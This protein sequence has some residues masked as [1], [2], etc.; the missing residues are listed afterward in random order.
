MS[1]KRDDEHWIRTVA[2]PSLVEN[3]K[4]T[5]KGNGRRAVLRSVEAKRLSMAESFMLTACYKANVVLAE[6]SGENADTWLIKLVVK[7]F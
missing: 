6:S 3:G 7:V 5:F 4:L 2:I 1:S